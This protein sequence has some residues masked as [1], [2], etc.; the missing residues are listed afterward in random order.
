M[1]LEPRN[2]EMEGPDEPHL[3]LM[4][5]AAGMMIAIPPGASL[6]F[7]EDKTQQDKIF[8]LIL[9][10]VSIKKLVFLMANADGAAT[11]YTYQL[12]SG[13]PLNKAALHRMVANKKGQATKFQK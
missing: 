13:K 11:E 1:P 4:Q 3:A 7:V 5:G 8:P 10:K 12:V 2:E 6:W 9:K